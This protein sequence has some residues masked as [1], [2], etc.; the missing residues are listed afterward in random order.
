MRGGYKV[1]D[2]KDIPIASTA[3][4]VATVPVVIEG[5]Y[6]SFEGN[7]FKLPVVHGLIVDEVEY[8]DFS[9][10]VSTTEGVFTFILE[11]NTADF[12]V[13]QVMDEDKVTAVKY[14][15]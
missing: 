1:L 11:H 7:Y 9:P 13:I 10:T 12:Y 3:E 6:E 8:W 2:F 14:T 4:G 15:N 5:I